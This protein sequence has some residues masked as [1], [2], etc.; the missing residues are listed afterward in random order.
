VGAIGLSLLPG[1]AELRINELGVQSLEGLAMSLERL[2]RVDPSLRPRVRVFPGPAGEAL[3]AA[4]WADAVIADPP[5]KGLDA[6]LR[7]LLAHT[8]PTRFWYVACGLEAFLADTERL[9][10]PGRLRLA[11][12]TAFDLM[13]Y[14]GHVETVARFEARHPA[15]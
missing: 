3:E 2:D 15:L 1:L 13:P 6:P 10:A 4:A 5:R 7:E 8:P 14:T 11:S 12:L 9:L